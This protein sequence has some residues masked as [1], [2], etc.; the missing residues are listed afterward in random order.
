MG[1]GEY[2]A[3]GVG[4][5]EVV[6]ERERVSETAREIRPSTNGG[7]RGPSGDEAELPPGWSSAWSEEHSE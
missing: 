2:G 5:R 1:Y 4:V 3:Y 7:E 6:R